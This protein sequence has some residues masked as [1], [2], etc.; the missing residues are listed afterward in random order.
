MTS[1]CTSGPFRILVP[2]Y[3]IVMRLSFNSCPV[4]VLVAFFSRYHPATHPKLPD[5][6][7]IFAQLFFSSKMVKLSPLVTE[8][9]RFEFKEA[10][11]RTLRLFAVTV[12]VTLLCT[13]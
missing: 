13:V 8:P 12:P 10:L 1:A 2:L 5:L 7:S 3:V 6:N 11:E 9:R 4:W